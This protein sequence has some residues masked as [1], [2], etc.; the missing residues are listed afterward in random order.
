MIG[1]IDNGMTL[2]NVNTFYKMIAS[3]AIL[4]IALALDRINS[5]D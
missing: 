3:G 5:K 2:L 4:I 1:V